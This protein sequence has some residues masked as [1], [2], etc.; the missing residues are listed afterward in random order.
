MSKQSAISRF[1]SRILVTSSLTREEVADIFHEL[2]RCNETTLAE[3]ILDINRRE[4]AEVGKFDDQ[5]AK[6]LIDYDKN[7]EYHH[8][9][10]KN[11]LL[12][13][14]K[15]IST[16]IA[17]RNVALKRAVDADDLELI[18]AMYDNNISQSKQSRDELTANFKQLKNMLHQK[19]LEDKR[20]L[21]A[22][23]RETKFMFEQE[24]IKARRDISNH[25]REVIEKWMTVISEREMM[26]GGAA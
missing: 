12:S 14:E 25:K 23:Q 21:Q 11:K 8:Q 19:M 1:I 24:R 22:E 17:Q 13:V 6:L 15:H 18:Y 20:A 9:E 2:D 26:K 7:L 3:I 16:M 5:M 10:Y 4:A